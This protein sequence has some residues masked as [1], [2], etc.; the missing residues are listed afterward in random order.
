LPPQ[1]SIYICIRVCYELRDR[2]SGREDISKTCLAE[3]R[4]M[5]FVV[6]RR[7]Y[8]IISRDMVADSIGV[9]AIIER[10]RRG[11]YCLI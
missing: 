6:A 4:D 7:R 3:Q 11:G 9:R 5:P 2:P 8:D 1:K 10:K